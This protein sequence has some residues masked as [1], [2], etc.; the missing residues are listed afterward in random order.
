MVFSREVLRMVTCN[1]PVSNC[2]RLS[3]SESL[4]V[5]CNCLPRSQE[6]VINPYSW[7]Y[8]TTDVAS[9]RAALL[10]AVEEQAMLPE[11]LRR[12]EPEAGAAE[13]DLAADT[14]QVGAHRNSSAQGLKLSS[15]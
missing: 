6:A 11:L 15:I 13:L 8:R 7:M 2:A 10:P 3:A 5:A 1:F 4:H 14:A 9:Y 12:V